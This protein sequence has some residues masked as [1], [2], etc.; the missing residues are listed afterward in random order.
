MKRKFKYM[1]ILK[2]RPSENKA[3]EKLTDF[4]DFFII[5]KCNKI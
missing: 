2:T 5:V 3:Y 4:F 1:P